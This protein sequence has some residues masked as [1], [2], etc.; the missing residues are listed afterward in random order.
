[1]AHFMIKNDRDLNGKVAVA[2]A[3]THTDALGEPPHEGTV[4]KLG[5]VG[6]PVVPH[7]A[8]LLDRAD[9][10]KYD[11]I[12][13]MDEENRRYMRRILGERENIYLLMDFTE[14]PRSVADPWYTGNFDE[15]Y[16]DLKE[17]LEALFSR[18]IASGALS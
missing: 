15:T 12:I 16:N 17:G 10:D 5:E 9:G 6:I 18:L 4:R 7:R 1:M 11:L 13:G 14:H 8:R 2:S 3:A